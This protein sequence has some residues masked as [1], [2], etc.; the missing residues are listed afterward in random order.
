MFLLVAAP[1]VV[2]LCGIFKAFL[3]APHIDLCARTSVAYDIVVTNAAF[4]VCLV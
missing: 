2:S 3:P 4:S 1:V